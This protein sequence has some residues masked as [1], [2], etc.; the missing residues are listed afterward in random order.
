MEPIEPSWRN[1]GIGFMFTPFKWKL[2]MEVE[3]EYMYIIVG[4]FGLEIAWS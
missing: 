3:S 2:S 1:M 4:P